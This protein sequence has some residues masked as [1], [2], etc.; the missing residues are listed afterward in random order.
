[1]RTITTAILGAALATSASGQSIAPQ[2]GAF[3]RPEGVVGVGL[4][5]PFGGVRHREAPRVE[6]RLA[7][8]SV[9][10]DGGRQSSTTGW[11]SIETRIGVSL[12]PDHKLM[13][14]G[15]PITNDRRHGVSTLGWVAIG[16]GVAALA[17]A[18]WVVNA[19]NDASRHND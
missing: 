4:T 7:R 6:L 15:R 10:I 9:N 2:G 5:I 1:M 16:V 14:N 12:A 3:S 11:R 18:A 19:M 8:D 17:G 13:L